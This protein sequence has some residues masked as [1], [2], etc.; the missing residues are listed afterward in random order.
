MPKERVMEFS[1]AKKKPF[2]E[3]VRGESEQFMLHSSMSPH[4]SH[5]FLEEMGFKHTYNLEKEGDRKK[6]TPLVLK[7]SKKL[8]EGVGLNPD[9]LK[10]YKIKYEYLPGHGDMHIEQ[11]KKEVVINLENLPERELADQQEILNQP[12]VKDL[13][14]KE[15]TGQLLTSLVHE[16]WH[17]DYHN[18]LNSKTKKQ[19]IELIASE[20]EDTYDSMHLMPLNRFDEL[21]AAMAEH[22]LRKNHSGLDALVSQSAHSKI[23]QVYGANGRTHKDIEKGIVLSSLELPGIGKHHLPVDVHLPTDLLTLESMAHQLLGHYYATVLEIKGLDANDVFNKIKQHPDT[24][25]TVNDEGKVGF[26][27]IGNDEDLEPVNTDKVL[28]E[29]FKDEKT[30]K[31]VKKVMFE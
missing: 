3:F 11:F 1:W 14:F 22:L 24:F 13:L 15:Y 18:T 9:I 4:S 26:L 27:K 12:G 30:R 16:A 28:T 10:D 31:I 25:A 8:F 5:K 6:F 23:I 7:A 19:D 21:Q 20:K 17:A 29:L 2:Q